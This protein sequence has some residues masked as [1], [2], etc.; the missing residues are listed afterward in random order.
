MMSVANLFAMGWLLRVS[1]SDAGIARYRKW[2][3]WGTALGVI[4]AATVYAVMFRVL[5]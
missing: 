5:S 4:A 3:T 2:T 1:V